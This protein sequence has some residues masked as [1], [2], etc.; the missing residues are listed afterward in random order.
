MEG[1]IREKLGYYG[2][3]VKTLLDMSESLKLMSSNP[4]IRYE[5]MI[6]RIHLFSKQINAIVTPIADAEYKRSVEDKLSEMIK[7]RRISETD[8]PFYIIAQALDLIRRRG[9]LYE[10]GIVA[11][12]TPDLSEG[13][14]TAD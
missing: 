12:I 6:K 11:E 3:I 10:L 2:I 5:D 14:E 9:G 4:T 13:W 8:I 7:E 1:E